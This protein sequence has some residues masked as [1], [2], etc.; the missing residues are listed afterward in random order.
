V[1]TR[2][3]WVTRYPRTIIVVGLLVVAALATGAARLSFDPRYA[4]FFD[5]DDPQLLAFEHL[6]DVFAPSDAVVF[7]VDPGER[8]PFSAQGLA[9]QEAL[10]EAAWRLPFTI[11]VDSPVN[12]AHSAADGD[13]IV[14]GPLV[15]DAAAL[16]AAGRAR[17]ERIARSAPELAGRLV[18]RDGRHVAVAATVILDGDPLAATD[19]LMTAARAV[20]ADVEARW[21]GAEVHLGGIVAMNHAFSESSLN[22][23]AVLL[24]AMLV[25]MILGLVWLLRAVLP[26]LVIV[27][28]MVGSIAGALGV[29]GWVGMVL[30]TPA[31]IAPII[32]V[33]VAIAD[34]V[35][36]VLGQRNA[37]EPGVLASV[38]HSLAENHWPILLTTATTAAGFLSMNF[39]AVPPFRDLGNLVAVGVVLAGALSLTV[40]P[41]ALCLL[42]PEQRPARVRSEHVVRLADTVIGFRGRGLLIVALVMLV[43]LPGLGRLRVN[44]DFVAYFDEDLPFRQAAEI[45][46][47][48]L[49][50]LYEIEYQLIAPGPDGIHDPAFLAQVAAFTDWLRA[51]PETAHVLSWTDVLR[52]LNRTVNGGDPAAYRL[53]PSVAAASQYTLLFELSLP[54]GLDTTNMLAPDHGSVRHLVTLRNLDSR[55]VLEFEARAGDW[56]AANAPAVRERHGG[57]NLM[58]AH[59]S[60]RNVAAMIEGNLL[61]VAVIAAMLAVALRSLALAGLSLATNLVPVAGAFA[62]WG[63]VVQDVGLALST[64]F[65][66]TLGI[67]VDDTV[68]L[69]SRY[70]RAR[71]AGDDPGAAARA[72][73][74]RVGPA[75]VVTSAILVAGFLVLAYSSFAINGQLARITVLTVLLALAF[76]LV[77]LP[78]LLARR[79]AP[80]PSGA[81]SADGSGDTTGGGR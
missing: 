63:W 14:I 81:A 74:L 40:L 34:G 51:Q 44:D 53:P 18:E 9:L 15:E 13:E 48:H 7:I 56:L 50:G 16:D 4:T 42:P 62:L 43:V 27:G 24:P 54:L 20:A 8:G 28:V 65:G 1:A 73:V 29:A 52:R 58:F 78:A 67:V 64:A 22:D 25:L 36:L 10:T 17:V 75:I 2:E 31:A 11:R 12:H 3:P 55:R 41:A 77:A 70:R 79:G 60:E 47:D 45:A 71:D 66:M 72:S 35:H 30:T 80:A 69:L 76:D 39:S 6:R 32:I 37:P 46:D 23:S 68:H 57:I 59:I 26:V 61:A 38:R 49:S 21:P 33:T 5:A 19:R